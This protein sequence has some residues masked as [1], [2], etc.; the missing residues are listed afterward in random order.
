MID[1][2]STGMR[3]GIRSGASK[4]LTVRTNI[5]IPAM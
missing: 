2:Q 5:T 3:G 4:K 1:W